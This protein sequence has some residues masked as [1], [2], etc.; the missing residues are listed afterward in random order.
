MNNNKKRPAVS[1]TT[2]TRRYSRRI[3]AN[4]NV[5]ASLDDCVDDIILS[6]AS[7]LTSCELFSFALT[8][9]RFG[10]RT[11]VSTNEDEQQEEDICEIISKTDS[12][13]DGRVR[14]AYTVLPNGLGV[15]A[16][17]S[18][19]GTTIFARPHQREESR[20]DMFMEGVIIEHIFTTDSY[21]VKFQNQK[22]K[23]NGN[24]IQMIHREE[25]VSIKYIT[26]K[27]EE[28]LRFCV[29]MEGDTISVSNYI[30]V[31]S[32][33]WGIESRFVEEVG[34]GM[35]ERVKSQLESRD[36][37]LMEEAALQKSFNLLSED[38]CLM[39]REGE[40]WMG[41]CHQFDQELNVLSSEAFKLKVTL[42]FIDESTDLVSYLQS[43]VS[44]VR[45][46]VSLMYPPRLSGSISQ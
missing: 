16:R 26:K 6:I 25:L 37:S 35:L 33:R 42:H 17:P 23:S 27:I 1:D 22:L 5:E 40:S 36:C 31:D 14:K 46:K 43:Y 28:S 13:F 34:S 3:N 21:R 9:K 2:L 10:A 18:S 11:M 4:N 29:K 20:E 24:N 32:E 44:S 45:W 12:D 19:N 30:L 38:G 15:F 39:W 41:I 7:Y 8:C